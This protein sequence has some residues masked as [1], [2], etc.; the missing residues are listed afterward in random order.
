[1]TIAA[2]TIFAATPVSAEAPTERQYLDIPGIGPVPIPLP[3]GSRIFSPQK[4][5]KPPVE[6]APEIE[7]RE[8][9][10]GNEVE[11][12]LADLTAADDE[13]EAGGLERAIARIWARSGSPTADLLM[14]RA[15]V[16]ASVGDHALA[17]D[18]FDHIVL[19]E[20][21]WPQALVGRADVRVALGDLSGAERDLETAVRLEPRRFD[22]FAALG[23]LHEQ[24][25]APAR[26]LDAY[27]RAF[28]L[29]PKR[30]EW[31]KAKERLE[32]EVMGRDI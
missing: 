11:S 25:G 26:A 13:S 31:R 20:P 19:L 21:N 17:L 6:P 2:V 32:L 29:D 18:L 30:P 27:R 10:R 24:T 9:R 8:K 5:V 1:M 14:A 7:S 22:A 4:R 12:L 3:P 23:A 16:A 28:A 15:T